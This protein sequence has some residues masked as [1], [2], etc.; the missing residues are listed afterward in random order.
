MTDA[1]TARGSIRRRLTVQLL[2]SAALLTV[3]LFFIVQSFARQLAEESQDN[4]LAASATSILDSATVQDGEISIDIP[5]SAFSMLGNVSDDRVFYAIWRDRDFLTGYD[6]L[7]RAGAASTRETPAFETTS[8]QNAT[9]RLVTAQRLVAINGRPTNLTISVGQTRNGQTETLARISRMALISGL[10]F[11]AVA[12]L[13]TLLATRAAVRP[14]NQLAA[15]VSRRGPQ[16]LRPVVAPVPAEM[17]PLVASLNGFI[18]RLKTSLTRSEDFIAEAAHR[19]R[20]PL[21]TVRTQAEITLRRVDKDENRASLKEMIR[22][23]DESSRAAGQLLDHAMVTFRTDHLS[24]EPVDLGALANDTTTRLNPLAELKDI[25]LTVAATGDN[26]TV[27]GDPILLQNAVR[28]L[29]DNAIKYSFSGSQVHVDVTRSDERLLFTVCDQGR[30][31]P[32]GDASGLKDRF[33]RGE[34]VTSIVGSGLGLTIADEVARAHNGTLTLTQN[35]KGV[36][37]CATLS[38]P[39]F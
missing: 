8:Y 24:Q 12:T 36:G 13:V 11:F 25:T 4:I 33:A 31:L 21:A 10:G 39:S 14:L 26:L 32:N 19:V 6:G 35:P 29:L 7:P 1:L 15:S 18:E 9:L 30:G 23:I 20:T 27:S 28:N 34:N 17:V 5:Y 38:F 3:V 37:T 16:D 22:A 2:S